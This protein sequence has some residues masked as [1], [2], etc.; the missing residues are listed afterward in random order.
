MRAIDTNVL[1][2]LIT[3]DDP[4]QPARAEDFVARGAW[5]SQLVLAETTWVLE[6]VYELAPQRIATALE[7]LLD[8]EHIALQGSEGIRAALQDFKKKPK[9]GFSD[10]LIVHLARKAGH[11]PLGTFDKALSKIEGA[12]RL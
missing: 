5:V 12:K 7:M 1:V 2:R 3:R 11:I 8:H 4:E 9:L 6:S 10:C